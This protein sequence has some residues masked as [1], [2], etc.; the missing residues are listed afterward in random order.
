[1]TS[2]GAG[3]EACGVRGTSGARETDAA[4]ESDAWVLPPGLPAPGTYEH[5][6]AGDLPI[7]YPTRDAVDAAALIATLRAARRGLAAIPTAEMVRILG[8]AAEAL[9]R[10]L[11]RADLVDIA[12]NGRLSPAMARAV[13]AGMAPSWTTAA[14]DRL[15]R[16][17][18]PDPRVLDG[19]VAETGGRYGAADEAAPDGRDGAGEPERPARAADAATPRRHVRAAGPPVTLHFGAGSVPGVTVTSMIRALLVRSAV[20]VKPGAGDIALT[21]RFARLL[22]RAD[23]RLARAVAVQYWPGGAPAWDGWERDLLRAADQVVVYGGDA[24]IEA[25]RARAP[26]TNRLIEHPHR[27]GVAIIGPG[28]APGTAGATESAAVPAAPPDGGPT[29]PAE[30][31]ARAAALFEQRGCVSTHLVLIVGSEDAARTFCTELAASLSALEARLPPAPLTAGELSARH[32]LRGHLAMKG[33]AL[34][35]AASGEPALGSPREPTRRPSV[36]HWPAA[37]G[38]W[39]VILSPPGDFEPAGART[40]WVA[41][42]SSLAECP[43]AL[44][45]L[46]PVLQT[47]GLAGIGHEHTTALAEDLFAL[48]ATRIVPLDQVPFPD[49]DW[50]HDGARP[51]RELVR[52]GE[53]RSRP[54]I[55]PAS[56]RGR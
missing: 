22:H 54:W 38:G 47:I 31:T 50:L 18:F 12:A 51:L 25:V 23:P 56:H 53:L 2:S 29:H 34:W 9:T 48:G 17:E 52:W 19:F 15:V 45:P 10:D 37:T 6:R 44:D 20:L 40:V 14:I 46:S 4:R 24:A 49:P 13:V 42:V 39:S 41:P 43:A 55:I 5:L 8:G 16:A 7:R 35:S 36:G 3:S 26:A 27:I 11:D 28:A 30:A 21:V 32:Q 1:M 33:A